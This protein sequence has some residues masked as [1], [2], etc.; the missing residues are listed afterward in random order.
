MPPTLRYEYTVAR[1]QMNFL[2]HGVVAG[3]INIWV[4]IQKT[5][6]HDGQIQNFFT[7]GWCQI[8]GLRSS[9]TIQQGGGIV[10][11]C[12]RTRGLVTG[13]KDLQNTAASTTHVDPQIPHDGVF[14]KGI[15][16]DGDCCNGVKINGAV[17]D[18]FPIFGIKGNCPTFVVRRGDNGCVATGV[19]GSDID[20][21]GRKVEGMPDYK[22]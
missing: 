15:I 13:Q 9:H 16:Q 20:G 4:V 2:P 19:G 12:Q 7:T 3:Q 21:V 22:D 10:H 1:R 14:G 11:V 18:I 17:P 8:N 6:I 5:M